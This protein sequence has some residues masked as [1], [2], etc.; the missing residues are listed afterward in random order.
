MYEI[1][2]VVYLLVAMAIIGLVLVGLVVAMTVVSFFWT[3]FDPTTLRAVGDGIQPVRSR[4]P[5]PAPVFEMP[6]DEEISA[7][8]QRGGSFPDDLDWDSAA[9]KAMR[10]T[11]KAL[12][13][14][15]GCGSMPK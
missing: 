4:V 11:A 13:G 1:L 2:L 12:S 7:F 15:L 5:A 10:E 8:L 9:A 3:P 14:R 6:A